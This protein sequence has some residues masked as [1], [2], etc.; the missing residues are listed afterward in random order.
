MQVLAQSA[1]PPTLGN[2][3]HSGTPVGNLG[4]YKGAC[5]LLLHETE[6]QTEHPSKELYEIQATWRVVLH[7]REDDVDQ[8]MVALTKDLTQKTVVAA[9]ALHIQEVLD[10]G[11]SW[12]REGQVLGP[13]AQRRV[14]MAHGEDE[15]DS[16]E[17]KG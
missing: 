17:T 16:K 11:G 10:G 2:I 5:I 3:P 4:A 12:L 1:I 7:T 6:E 13:V 8:A 14:W 9:E 15:P